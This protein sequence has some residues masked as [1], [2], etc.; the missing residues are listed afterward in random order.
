MISYRESLKQ[1]LSL[2]QICN[3]NNL[4]EGCEKPRKAVVGR[5]S[6]MRPGDR[7]VLCNYQA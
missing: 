4:D 2:R 7:C 3:E 5:D 6:S 1:R